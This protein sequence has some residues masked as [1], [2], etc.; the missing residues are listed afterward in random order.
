M[1]AEWQLVA[2][3]TTKRSKRQQ[4]VF[5]KANALLGPSYGQRQSEKLY[6]SKPCML[7]TYV[8]HT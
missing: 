6:M 4:P 8:N 2:L 1:I 5:S 3:L 7:V